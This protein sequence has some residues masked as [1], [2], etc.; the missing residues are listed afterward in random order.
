MEDQASIYVY[1]PLNEARREICPLHLQTRC[2]GVILDLESAEQQTL[3]FEHDHNIKCTFSLA[4]LDN[5]PY[6]EARSYVWGEL[7]GSR[8]I[9][10]EGHEFLVTRSLHTALHHMRLKLEERIIWIDALCIDQGSTEERSSQAEHIHSIFTLATMVIV[11]L[12]ELWDGCNI[13]MDYITLLGSDINLHLDPSLGLHALRHDINANLPL[14]QIYLPRFFG[15]LWFDRT[16][17]V[18]EFAFARAAQFRRGDYHLDGQSF[19]TM[20]RI[21]SR[22]LRTAG[23]RRTWLQILI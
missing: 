7:Q 23:I 13:A 20:F 12:G 16:W 6:Y 14:L 22:I 11:F 18:Q 3:A 21:T 17:T 9:L 15:S 4:T 5:V 8:T 10:L 2:K 19:K 1:T